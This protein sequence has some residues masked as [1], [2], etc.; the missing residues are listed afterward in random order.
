MEVAY[1]WSALGS[2]LVLLMPVLALAAVDSS[3]PVTVTVDVSRAEPDRM[4]L[5]WRFRLAPDWHLY[6]PFRNDTGFAPSIDLELPDGWSA[7]D[8]AWPAPE[9]WLVAGEIL[10]HVYHHELALLQS[11]R[12]PLGTAP[13]RVPATLRWLACSEICVPGDTT[14]TLMLPAPADTSVGHL[15]ALAAASV[16]AA[17]PSSRY[18]VRRD[19]GHLVIQAPGASR[20][21]FVAGI[22]GPLFGDLAAAGAADAEEL[23]LQFQPGPE[24]TTPLRGLL[25]IID[26]DGRRTVGW[27]TIP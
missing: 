5:L 13:R 17:M 26:T 11:V 16:P 10:D 4:T 22:D 1:K 14:M 15:A 25:T 3:V 19:P 18:S 23:T 20:L 7:E 9:R 6:A 8:L 12:V 2:V 21:T 27:I 24:S